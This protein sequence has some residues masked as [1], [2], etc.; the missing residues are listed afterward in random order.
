MALHPMSQASCSNDGR[1]QYGSRTVSRR[2]LLNSGR[3]TL[4]RNGRLVSQLVGL[5]RRVTR[6]GKDSIDHAPGG[7]DDLINAVAGVVAA[8]ARRDPEEDFP[9]W[10]RF[11]PPTPWDPARR[12]RAE[13]E[14]VQIRMRRAARLAAAA[15]RGAGGTDAEWAAAMRNVELGSAPCTIEFP[16]EPT[17]PY[18]GA[19]TISRFFKV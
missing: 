19:F 12:Q 16:P 6:A 1:R 11:T 2:P 10:Y 15:R 8:V 4:P 13:A 17:P 7:H 3:V 14:A 18:P 5:E 9:G